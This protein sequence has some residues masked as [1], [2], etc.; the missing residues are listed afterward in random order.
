MHTQLNTAKTQQDTPNV[1]ILHSDSASE[2]LRYLRT[3]GYNQPALVLTDDTENPQ[4]T[5]LEAD[6]L[7][8]ENVTWDVLRAG[9]LPNCVDMLL[10]AA[11][12]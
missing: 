11:T 1:L 5:P 9:K 2:W 8:L 6:L 10:S 7:P 4:N 12:V 3:Q